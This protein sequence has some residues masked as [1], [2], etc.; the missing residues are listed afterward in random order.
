MSAQRDQ[1]LRGCWRILIGCG[2][3]MAALTGSAWGQEIVFLNDG[4]DDGERLTQSPPSSAQW[5][6]RRPAAELFVQSIDGDNKLRTGTSTTQIW[7]HFAPSGS[8]VVLAIGDRLELSAEVSWDGVFAPE[9]ARDRS[10]GFGL[11]DSKGTRDTADN[12]GNPGQRGDDTGYLVFTNPARNHESASMIAGGLTS[13]DHY[14]TFTTLQQFVSFNWGTAAQNVWLTMTRTG[15]SEMMLEAMIGEISASPQFTDIAASTFSYDTVSF[16][17]DNRVFENSTGRLQVDDVN[18]KIVPGAMGGDANRD[19]VVNI[20]DL[21]ILAANWQSS[22][23]LWEHAD[24]NYDRQ[25]NIA[26]LGILA[27]NWQAGAENGGLGF[28]EAM[29]MFDVFDGVVVP[30]PALGLVGLAGLVI[31]RRPRRTLSA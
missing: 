16:F 7:A 8:P 23:A 19:G 15:E 30:E 3:G 14:V 6:N 18:V 25:V 20:A 2:V 10:L 12:S 5:F 26:D 31:Q 22:G 24:F 1:A 11:W 21:G 29:A 13:S 28:A 17:F 4:F 27:A 9:P